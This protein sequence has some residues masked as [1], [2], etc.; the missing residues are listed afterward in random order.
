MRCSLCGYVLEDKTDSCP[1]CHGDISPAKRRRALLGSILLAAIAIAVVG[2]L[3]YG[4][5][6]WHD[7]QAWERMFGPD[8]GPNHAHM[9]ASIILIIS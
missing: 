1:R 3:V 2:L 6:Y 7:T 4:V 8:P 5:L 9:A